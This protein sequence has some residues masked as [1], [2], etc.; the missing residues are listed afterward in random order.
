MKVHCIKRLAKFPP[1]SGNIFLYYLSKIYLIQAIPAS[2]HLTKEE[3]L[4]KTRGGV[5]SPWNRCRVFEDN[6]I[7]YPSSS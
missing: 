2:K 7:E 6:I 3:E 1:N 5:I 4:V